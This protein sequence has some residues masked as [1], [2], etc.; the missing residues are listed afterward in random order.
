M[1]IL[2]MRTQ[3]D[4]GGEPGSCFGTYQVNRMAGFIQSI[5][6]SL[7]YILANGVPACCFGSIW[8]IILQFFTIPADFG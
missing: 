2:Q 1:G 5:R 6:S 3:T 8:L 4:Q 7:A